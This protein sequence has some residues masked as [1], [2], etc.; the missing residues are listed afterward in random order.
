MRQFRNITALLL[1]ALLLVACG[2]GGDSNGDADASGCRGAVAEAAEATNL[3]DD[4]DLEPAFAACQDLA[5]FGSAVQD[6]PEAL[7]G[8]GADV[9]GW[10]QDRCQQSDTLSG[11]PLCESIQ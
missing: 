9:E 8:I 10:V 1:S 11:T 5:E 3:E 7:E 4:V 2:N 6:S